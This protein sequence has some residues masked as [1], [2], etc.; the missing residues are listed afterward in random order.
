L[1]Q[2]ADAL[3]TL[4]NGIDQCERFGAF[5]RL[6]NLYNSLAYCYSEI[7]QPEQSW[8]FNRKSE[9]I[10]RNLMEKYPM[11]RRQWAHC[12]GEANANL[13]ENLIDQG[14]LEAAWKRL[15]AME[16]ESKSSD[17]DMNR[18]QWESRMQYL[19]AQILVYR[20]DFDQ[21]EAIIQRNLK[22]VR[23]VQM[24]KREGGFLRILGE[25][26]MRNNETDSAMATLNKSIQIL[27]EVGNPR[28]L[29]QAHG[30]LAAVFDETGRFGEA[31]EQ[32]GAASQMIQ[33]T[34]D[35]LT[36][37]ELKDQF[38]HA[39]PIREILSKAVIA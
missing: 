26:Q 2:I 9:D 32:W 23:K 13:V 30:S 37:R 36:D 22:K 16:E 27:K 20:N 34:A 4:N 19:V 25:V 11:G 3:T 6:G 12:L 7:Y 14:N 21:A 1:G 29:W 5:Y 39:G 35:G 24:K 8:V 15:K 33:N 31:R 18:Y 17:F 10:S 38:L 28:H